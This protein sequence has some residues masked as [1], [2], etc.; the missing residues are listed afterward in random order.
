[1]K[2]SYKVLPVAR[3]Y[4]KDFLTILDGASN[5]TNLIAP[6]RELDEEG[7]SVGPSHLGANPKH[8]WRGVKVW[9]CRVGPNSERAIRLGADLFLSRNC[10]I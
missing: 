9:L 7:T 4:L 10:S 3:P 1:M 2:K 5:K 6:Y 8:P